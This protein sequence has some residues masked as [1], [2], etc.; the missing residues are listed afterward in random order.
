MVNVIGWVGAFGL[1]FAFVLSS[2]GKLDNKGLVYHL[3]NFFS[4]LLLAINAFVFKAYPFLLV[5]S[6]WAITSVVSIFHTLKE[7]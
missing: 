7:K 4:A 1:L 6:F 3:I 2:F 5:N